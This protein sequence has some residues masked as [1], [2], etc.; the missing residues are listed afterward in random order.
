MAKPY[1]SEMEQLNETLDWLCQVDI[2]GLVKS[3]KASSDLPLVAIGSGGSLS[4]AHGLATN[5]RQ[6]AGKLSNVATPLEVVREPIDGQTANWLLSAGGRNVDILAAARALIDREPRQ[7]TVVTGRDD[8][9]LTDLCRA[10][11]F[12]DLHIYPPPAG[13]DGFL[14]TNSLLGFAGLLQRAYTSLFGQP[15]DW[16]KTVAVLRSMSDPAFS[17]RLN[18]KEQ[19][20]PLWQRTTTVILYGPSTRLG[21][22]D[23][24]SKFTEAALGSIQ[25]ADFRNFAHGR[26]HWLAKRG[27]DSGV[28][29][30]VAPEDKMLAD[31][32][33]ELLPDDIPQLSIDLPGGSAAGLASLLAAFKLTALAGIAQRIDPGRPGV[34]M[35]GRKLYKLT[36]PKTP[37]R[38]PPH[39]I[40]GRDIVAIERKTKQSFDRLMHSGSL[41]TWNDHLNSFRDGLLKETFNA[42]VLDYDG[43]IVETRSRLDPPSEGIVKKLIEMLEA[44]IWVCLATGRG[45]SARIDLQKCIPSTHWDKVLLGYYNGAEVSSLSDNLA[46]NGEARADGDLHPASELLNANGLICEFFEQEDRNHQITLTAKSGYSADHLYESV[47]E[48]LSGVGSAAL[49]VVRSG[50]S[51]DIL[52]PGVSKLNVADAVIQNN[53]D[54]SILSIGDSGGLNGNDHELLT[55]PHSLGV[56]KINADPKTCWNL[57]A[58]GQRGPSILT[59]YLN[60]IICSEGS[61]KFRSGA[62]K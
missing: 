15:E 42:V 30:L 57:G 22:M 55:R 19:A 11:P 41:Q 28:L 9:K 1:A 53:P 62:L 24:E 2:S 49:S 58:Q 23:I 36:P 13:K 20:A 61:F 12:V 8:T 38:K 31:K 37:K 17:H 21:A 33:M 6:F 50:H 60:A 52:A 39:G 40:S 44:D 10:H 51:I 54:A 35:F 25:L 48:L 14:A 47:V 56:D 7:L 16:N 29:A 5:H 18:L 32:T 27:D 43:T 46:P 26:H 59:E 45:K 34:P 3:L 4:A